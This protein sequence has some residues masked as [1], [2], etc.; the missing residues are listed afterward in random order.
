MTGSNFTDGSSLLAPTCPPQPGQF[1]W[2]RSAH[3]PSQNS[4]CAPPD[5]AAPPLSLY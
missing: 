1:H 2:S 5:L 4:G 3:V